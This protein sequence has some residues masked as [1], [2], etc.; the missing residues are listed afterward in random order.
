MDIGDAKLRYRS[1]AWAEPSTVLVN[2]MLG[3]ALV[4]GSASSQSCNM[5][6]RNT[7][8]SLR[9][10]EVCRPCIIISFDKPRSSTACT[11]LLAKKGS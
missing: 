2:F 5:S 4:V 11:T 1:S 9:K 3:S 8:H 6:R 10:G 7:K